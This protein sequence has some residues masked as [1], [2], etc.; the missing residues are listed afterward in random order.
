MGPLP[1]RGGVR[2]KGKGRVQFDFKFHGTRYRPTIAAE[3]T[4]ANLRRARAKL[5]RIKARI[6]SGTFSFNEEFPA[7]RYSIIWRAPSAVKRATRYSMRTSRIVQHASRSS[8][9]RML[10]SRAIAA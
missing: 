2:A 9:S 8:T 4:E 3:T 10:R 7:Y 6:V 5:R 1:T